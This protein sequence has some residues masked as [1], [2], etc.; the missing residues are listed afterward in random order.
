[1]LWRYHIGKK[2]PET[3]YT[4]LLLHI[5]VVPSASS[6]AHVVIALYIGW[7]GRFYVKGKVQMEAICSWSEASYL[8][9]G[10]SRLSEEQA[11][12]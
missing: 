5:D 8:V 3:L 1:M 6:V 2:R 10:T 4:M 11:T 12:Q 9:G 7:A